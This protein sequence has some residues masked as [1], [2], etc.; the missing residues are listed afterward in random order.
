MPITLISLIILTNPIALISL[1]TPTLKTQLILIILV[2]LTGLTNLII[3]LTNGK[4]QDENFEEDSCTKTTQK[5]TMQNNTTQ[6][7]QKKI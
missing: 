3:L 2:Y 7:N 4:H 1:I 6:Y 5:E